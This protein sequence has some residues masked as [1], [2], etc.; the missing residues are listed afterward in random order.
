MQRSFHLICIAFVA[1]QLVVVVFYVTV[2]IV[3]VAAWLCWLGPLMDCK[4][5]WQKGF[6]NRQMRLKR[7]EAEGTGDRAATNR[8]DHPKKKNSEKNEEQKGK[9]ANAKNW[10]QTTETYIWPK[11]GGGSGEG[12]AGA[13]MQCALKL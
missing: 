7:R 3:V 1:V 11:R 4:S 8:G 12:G 13:H 6:N 10:H 2:V 5:F 9:E